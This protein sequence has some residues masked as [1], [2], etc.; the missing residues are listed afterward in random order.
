MNKHDLAA[1]RRSLLELWLSLIQDAY[2]NQQRELENLLHSRTG[3]EPVIPPMLRIPKPSSD[4]MNLLL[5]GIAAALDGKSN[6]F[7]V[8]APSKGIKPLKTRQQMISIVGELIAEIEALTTA[9]KAN[10]KTEALSKIATKHSLS[11]STLLKACKD[12]DILGMVKLSR[13]SVQ[14]RAYKKHAD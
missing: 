12:K 2:D 3:D 5:S 7:G 4:M 11:D 13:Y 14:D 8:E 10:P 6:P 1:A 9:G